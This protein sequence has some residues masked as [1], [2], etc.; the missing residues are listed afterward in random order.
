[1]QCIV[2][3]D[4]AELI[5]YNAFDNYELGKGIMVTIPKPGK[6]R[7]VQNLRPIVLLN[8]IRKILSLVV[9][10]RINPK[11]EEF[12]S[13]SQCAFR[14]HRGTSDAV[15]AHKF[16]CARALKYKWPIFILGID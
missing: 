1:M 9:L 10:N 14:K 12:L 13:S 2:A 15:W 6:P 4:I 3:E 8:N 16:I 5:N 11:V 7:N